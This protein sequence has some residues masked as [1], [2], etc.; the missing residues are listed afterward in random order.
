MIL[1]N[2]NDSKR[3]VFVPIPEDTEEGISAVMVERKNQRLW[4]LLNPQNNKDIS[5]VKER[6]FYE[7]VR[8]EIGANETIEQGIRW[9]KELFN[10]EKV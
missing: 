10:Q 9:D 3:E 4:Q 1:T 7:F 5:N 2:H 6:L 8:V